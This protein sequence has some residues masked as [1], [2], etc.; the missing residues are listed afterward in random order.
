[1]QRPQTGPVQGARILNLSL[2]RKTRAQFKHKVSRDYLLALGSIALLGLILRLIH[3]SVLFYSPVSDMVSYLR[4]AD[5]PFGPRSEEMFLYPPGYPMFLALVRATVGLHTIKPALYIQSFLDIGTLLLLSLTA[6]RLFSPRAA[7]CTAI[8][9]SIY[10][11]AILSV[12]LLMSETL[13][14]FLTTAFIYGTIQYIRT[15]RF[16]TLTLLAFIISY[17]ILVRTNL[18]PLLLIMVVLALFK[19]RSISRVKNIK[20]IVFFMVLATILVLPWPL[21]NWRVTGQKPFISTNFGMNFIQGNNEYSD[22]KYMNLESLP[23]PQISMIKGLDGFEQNRVTSALGKTFIR[24]H[25]AYELLWLIPCKIELLFLEP[26]RYPWDD[27]YEGHFGTNPFGPYLKFPLI[28]FYLLLPLSLLGLL[29]KPKRFSMLFPLILVSLLAPLLIFNPSARLR[30]P[31]EGIMVI[32]ASVPLAIAWK[33]SE[34]YRLKWFLRGSIAAIVIGS[35]VYTM[36]VCG[37]NKLLS[38]N[39][40]LK[41]ETALEQMTSGEFV[42]ISTGNQE[43]IPICDLK[44]S[45]GFDPFLLVQFDYRIETTR[46]GDWERSGYTPNFKLTYLDDGGNEV[47]RP[48]S[49]PYLLPANVELSSR[50]ESWGS[51]WRILRLPAAARSL[52]IEYVNNLPG[53]VTI[54]NLSARGAIW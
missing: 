24:Q 21:R 17:M 49:P 15:P 6:R 44:V 8:L 26:T 2:V 39:S 9:Y 46:V 7:V 35:I 48:I 29:C 47:K 45:P 40:L 14:L 31:A 50:Q 5:G 36:S 33:H 27:G 32:L 38:N 30:F 10:S 11:N 22:G 13:A 53:V 42:Q 52:K 25:P 41:R 12:G 18:A 16:K 54:R 37:P 28:P 4:I 19:V 43:P 20:R 1:M 3:V 34:L 23:E 51:A